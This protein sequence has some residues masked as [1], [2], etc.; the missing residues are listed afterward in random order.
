M[1]PIP[2]FGRCVLLL[3]RL[4][5]QSLPKRWVIW[6]DLRKAIEIIDAP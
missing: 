3:Q 4:L 1:A 5:T 2:D 6:C